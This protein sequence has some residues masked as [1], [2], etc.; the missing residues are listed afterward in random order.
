M[1]IWDGCETTPRLAETYFSQLKHFDDELMAWTR[2]LG[3]ESEILRADTWPIVEYLKL[4][5]PP[6][7]LDTAYS[8]HQRFRRT[9]ISTIG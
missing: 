8:T 3:A 9:S 6:T 4:Y 5:P 2:S 1:N 7:G